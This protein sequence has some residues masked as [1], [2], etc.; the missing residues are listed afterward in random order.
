MVLLAALAF[1][2]GATDLASFTQLG[3][4]FSSVMTGNLVLLGLAAARAAGEVAAHTAVA[5][6]GYIAGVALGSRI[7]RRGRRDDVVW[8]AAVTATLLVELVAF[9]VLTVGWELTSSRPAGAWQLSLLAVAALSIRP[10][11][12][13]T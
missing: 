5:F 11:P 3:G 6:A 9:A 8:P 10:C 13:R 1:G 4:V 12:P 2:G 7:A